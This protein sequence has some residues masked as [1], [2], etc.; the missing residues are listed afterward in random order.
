[1]AFVKGSQITDAVSVVNKCLGR[2]EHGKIGSSLN[3]MLKKLLSICYMCAR[4]N[5]THNPTKLKPA[6][7]WDWRISS[8]GKVLLLPIMHLMILW[9]LVVFQYAS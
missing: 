9:A 3:W 8:H 5:G 7:P 4:E 2:M 6:K 1:M